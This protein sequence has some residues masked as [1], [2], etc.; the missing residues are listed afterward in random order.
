MENNETPNT[1]T[2]PEPNSRDSKN[3]NSVKALNS[4]RSLPTERIASKPTR[5]QR[6]FSKKTF[7]ALFLLSLLLGVV[8]GLELSYQ[9]GL[10]YDAQ[11][12]KQLADYKP[13]LV[14]Q[15]IADDG[16]T[17]IGEFSLERR[18]PLS[19]DE[20]PLKMR[21]AVMAIE[22]A[23]FNS[24]WGIDPIGIAR[25]GWRNFQAGATVEGGSTLTQQLAKM[26]FLSP[27]KSLTRKAKEALLALQIE[28]QFTKQQ[29]MEFYCNQIFLGGGSYGIEAGAQY[30][31]GKAVKDLELEEIALLAGLPKAPSAYSPTRD[32]NR[33][34]T[35]RNLVIDNMAEEGF[36][37]RAEA[38]KA[39]GKPIKLNV[40]SRVGNNNSPYG[41]FVEEVRQYLEESYGTRVAHTSGMKVYTTLSADAQRHAVQAVRRGLHDYSRRH[42]SSAE[43]KFYNVID[44]E[45]VKNLNNYKHSDWDQEIKEKMYLQGLVMSVE[46]KEAKIKLGEYNVVLTSKELA[47]L[48]QP[49]NKILKKG[50]LAICYVKKLD[51]EKKEISITLEKLPQVAGAFVCI[52][53]RTGEIKAMVGGY[54]FNLSKF[55]NAT[56]GN[57]QTGSSFKP[58]VYSAALEDG[59]LADEY[60]SDTPVAYGE[61]S[62]RNYDG[63]FMG[64]ITLRKA[65]AQSRNIPAV[66]LLQSVGI[67]KGAEVVK[68]FGISNPMAPYLPSALGATEVPLIEMVAAYS[69]FPNQGSRAKPYYIKRITDPNGRLLEEKATESVPVVSPYVAATMVSLMQGVV[70]AGTARRIKSEKEA[71][72]NERPIAGKTGTVNDFTDAWFIGYTPSLV[73]GFWIGYQ[74]EKKSLGKGETGATSALPVWIDFMK[75]YLKDKEIEKFPQ[76]P[77]PDEVL[78]KVQE[79]RYKERLEVYMSSNAAYGGIPL[80]EILMPED[81]SPLPKKPVLAVPPPPPGYDPENSTDGKDSA[82]SNKLPSTKDATKFP[83]KPTVFDIEYPVKPPSLAGKSVKSGEKSKPS[84]STLTPKGATPSSTKP[85]ISGAKPASGTTKPPSTKPNS[86]STNSTNTNKPSATNSSPRVNTSSIEPSATRPRVVRATSIPSSNSSSKTVSNIKSISNTKSSTSKPTAGNIAK[87][88]SKA[89]LVSKPT[90]KSTTTKANVNKPTSSSAKR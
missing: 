86:G 40:N 44:N 27:E 68:R 34:T 69:T 54:D 63:S 80:P 48:K 60:I 82:H 65:I 56:Q 2:N 71:K 32:I 53:A 57:R 37:T 75:Y 24:H 67:Q 72:L 45:N 74:G 13:S 20:I 50:D 25:A 85:P 6:F 4:T 73:A 83:T 78:K 26:L 51:P 29:I 61:W 9:Y 33:A 84:S 43:F 87:P 18:M 70:E 62:P 47:T 58:F 81:G 76:T 35:R 3:V 7:L 38:T 89:T 11:A 21:Q 23:R 88:S 36:I 64:P 46:E 28:R 49:L 31:F 12:V 19:Y 77:E 39:K 17:I 42:P 55:N 59:W 90:V 79:K 10:T 16:K 30:Y 52:E 14:T 66:K 8:T 22:D 1:G 5:L 15:V 41:Y